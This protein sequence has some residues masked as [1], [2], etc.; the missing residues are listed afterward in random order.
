MHE[1]WDTVGINYMEKME[2]MKPG[3]ADGGD[4]FT[5]RAGGNI[6]RRFEWDA[7]WAVAGSYRA[8]VCDMGAASL[9]D[10]STAAWGRFLL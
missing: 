10:S 3:E 6:R 7:Q 8:E 1:A 9:S 2:A 4:G 5:A